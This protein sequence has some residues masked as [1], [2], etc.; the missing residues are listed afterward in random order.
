MAMALVAGCGPTTSAPSPP[1]STTVAP[2][3]PSATEAP[4]APASTA[5]PVAAPSSGRPAT[6]PPVWE[7]PAEVVATT[8]ACIRQWE[9]GG[10]VPGAAD[11]TS[12]SGP[13][14]GAYQ[15]DQ[16]TWE[17]VGGTGAPEDASPAE[18][19]ARAERLLAER[20]LQPW[21]TPSRRCA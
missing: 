10:G 19:D 1:P 3:D 6:S 15:F 18:Q 5:A 17:S 11:Y 14:G 8:L 20:G 16:G 12:R 2:P 21:P 9:T 4:P 7:V 13:H